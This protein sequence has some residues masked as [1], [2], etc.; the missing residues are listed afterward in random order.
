[1]TK[2]SAAD[3]INVNLNV[4]GCNNNYIC[5]AVIG[6]NATSCPA[7]CGG[8]TTTPP[9][10]T[11]GDSDT[12]GRSGSKIYQNEKGDFEIIIESIETTLSSIKISWSSGMPTN[13]SIT[14]SS[15]SGYNLGSLQEVGFTERHNLLLTNLVADTSYSIS[16]I[17]VDLNGASQNR[18][19]NVTTQKGAT[20]VP[21]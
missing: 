4:E 12:G 3:S 5:E 7:D 17:A 9:I 8:A 15:G 2:V 20:S 11:P 10:T 21:S 16:L 1:M 19:L 13:G 6:E 14:W 18:T